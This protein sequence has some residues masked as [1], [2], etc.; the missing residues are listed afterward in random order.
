MFAASNLRKKTARGA[1]MVLAA[2]GLCT[3]L[4]GSCS[5]SGG[6]LI[7]I[8][9][10]R[11]RVEPLRKAGVMASGESCAST[12][13]EADHK[14]RRIAQYNLRSLSGDEKYRITYVVV[15]RWRKN[16]NEYCSVVEAY[17]N[18]H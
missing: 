12:R 9:D 8:Q 1:V 10:D 7:Y 17:A 16:L 4:S 15:D 18:G 3:V 5:E 11:H 13:D 6:E 14:A 2:A